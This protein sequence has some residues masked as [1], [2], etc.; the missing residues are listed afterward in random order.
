MRRAF[1][2]LALGLLVGACSDA[3]APERP[4]RTAESAASW[5]LDV[6]NENALD[7]SHRGAFAPPLRQEAQ[8][9]AVRRTVD[10]VAADGP[11]RSIDTEVEGRSVSTVLR[12]NA[13]RS[14]LLHLERD[15]QG[16]IDVLWFGPAV[17]RAIARADA[18]TVQRVASVLPVQWSSVTLRSGDEGARVVG[19]A[20]DQVLPL[21]SVAKVVVAAAVVDQVERGELVWT[22]RVRVERTDVS[23]PATDA[24]PKPGDT[25]SIDELVRAMVAASDNT[26]TDV[27]L[28]T[29]GPD[30]V[31]Q[32][33]ERVT[34]RPWAGPFLSTKQ[35]LEGGWGADRLAPGSRPTSVAARRLLAD[36]QARPVET[37][38]MSATTPRWMD[39]LDWTARGSDLATLALWLESRRDRVGPATAEVLGREFVKPGG[40]PGVV[41]ELRWRRDG[42]RTVV[43]ITQFAG[44]STTDVG[45]AK[46]LL[47]L[48]DRSIEVAR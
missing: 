6:V 31:R 10:A 47:M 28:R 16:R 40:A 43:T 20:G 38:P 25:P 22:S 4:G 14:L 30:A 41:A 45:D 7:E 18:A 1:V 48:A 29:V 32:T 39:G 23:L 27:L 44:R 37:S 12:S 3:S 15:T 24:T 21:A 2:V 42:G 35:V 19:S 5:M 36:L 17:D 33:W 9:E 34:G 46:G 8:W 26:S 13:G 11:W